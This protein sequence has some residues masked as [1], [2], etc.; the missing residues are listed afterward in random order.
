MY[1]IGTGA[2][3]VNAVLYARAHNLP[4]DGACCRL[5][6]GTYARLH[7]LGVE[8]IEAL[9]PNDQP[10]I[11]NHFGDGLVVSLNN[12]YPLGEGLLSCG[13]RFFHI[14]NGPTER[15]R[16]IGEVCLFAALCA[17]DPTYA[18]TLHQL[19]PGAEAGTGPIVAQ[20]GLAWTPETSFAT[21]FRYALAACDRVFQQHV[22]ALVDGT[23]V[24]SAGG[25]GELLGYKDVARIY[26]A[27]DPARRARAC[28][29]GVYAGWLPQ[30]GAAIAQ[31]EAQ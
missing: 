22:R 27:A 25:A 30:L 6:D 16:G 12:P 8:V 31:L 10:W 3:V 9:D 21:A 18:A 28:D 13:A 20:E 26:A 1:F 19:L 14:H 29:L 7:R 23:A 11:V 17:G 2:P 5:G 4:I 24:V 15:Y